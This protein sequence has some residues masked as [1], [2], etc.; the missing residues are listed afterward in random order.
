MNYSARD[1]ILSELGFVNYA[2]YLTSPTW[3]RIRQQVLAAFPF[4]DCGAN[5][6]QVHHAE[7]TRKNLTGENL[8]HMRGICAACHE[9]LERN[10]DGTKRPPAAIT[11]IEYRRLEAPAQKA[12][13]LP[14]NRDRRPPKPPPVKGE[15]KKS[16]LRKFACIQCGFTLVAEA[17]PEACPNCEKPAGN[18]EPAH[19]GRTLATEPRTERG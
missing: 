19:I 6:E 17:K 3:F 16:K 9:R 15:R 5:S 8:A 1:K 7:Y 13:K 10:A 11:K 18:R 12:A 2:T 4:C 14:K